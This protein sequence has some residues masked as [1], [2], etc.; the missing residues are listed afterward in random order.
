MLKYFKNDITVL[1]AIAG[2]QECGIVPFEGMPDYA[3]YYRWEKGKLG[4]LVGIRGENV[5][6][7]WSWQGAADEQD[8]KY[9]Y[10]GMAWNAFGHFI[11]ETITRAWWQLINLDE[12]RIP[13]VIP[14]HT[15]S[16]DGRSVTHPD[17]AKWEMEIWKYLGAPEICLVDKPMRF[18]DAIVAEQG[19]VLFGP[20]HD[21]EY[22]EILH[23]YNIARQGERACNRK[24][25]F[26]RPLG[27]TG[28]IIGESI[29]GELLASK[30]YE[31]IRPETLS[32]LEQLEVARNAS[33]V[34]GAQGS[35]MHIY[36][37]LGKSPDTSIL[38]LTRL[39]KYSSDCF[40]ETLRPYVG[41]VTEVLPSVRFVTGG[42]SNND[43]TLVNVDIIIEALQEFDAELTFTRT[44]L[45][46]LSTISDL[47]KIFL[48]SNGAAI[49][50]KQ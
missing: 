29:I 9:Y 39:G 24:I 21:P 2:K 47:N 7:N 37:L 22:R 19:A 14:M 46:Q 18:K 17:P 31:I 49:Y 6:R 20:D 32:V 26:A 43:A 44:D 28:Q 11:T 5:R 4:P 48:G 45:E 15:Q 30:G 34:V 23:D 36:N 8:G 16:E 33:H 27:L 50:V 41:S 35:A 38:S 3:Y 13:I 10:A 1:P 25:F 42:S 12:P 40:Y